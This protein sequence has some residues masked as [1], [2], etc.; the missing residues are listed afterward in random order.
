[1]ITKPES[2]L[3]VAEV[4][5]Q[6]DDL[7]ASYKSRRKVLRALLAVLKDEAGVEPDKAEET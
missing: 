7:E 1:M 4:E 5:K 2:G 6:L 3:T